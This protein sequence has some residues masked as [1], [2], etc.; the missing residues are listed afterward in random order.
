MPRLQPPVACLWAVC[1]VHVD[2]HVGVQ[3]GIAELALE[4]LLNVRD[5]HKEVRR[6]PDAQTRNVLF[7]PRAASLYSM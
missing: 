4:N 1:G 6:C 5:V 7:L 3:V 2:S